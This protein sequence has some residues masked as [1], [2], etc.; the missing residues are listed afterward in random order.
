MDY[1]HVEGLKVKGKH[2]HYVRERRGEQEF[3]VSLRVAVHVQKAGKT[4]KLRHSVNYAHLKAIVEEVFR[5]APR[6]LLET[7]AEEIAKKVLK[8]KKVREITVTVKKL[9]IWNNG[10]P[11]VT[12]VRAK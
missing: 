10:V 12:I 2:G 7:L 3:E 5:R 11:G 1:I 8:E 9:K 4:D 6:Y